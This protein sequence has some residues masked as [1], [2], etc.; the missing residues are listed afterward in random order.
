MEFC[1]SP[2]KT[3]VNR[4][5]VT[6]ICVTKGPP[7]CTL[8]RNLEQLESRRSFT[9]DQSHFCPL[10]LSEKVAGV[11]PPACPSE[12]YVVVAVTSIRFFNQIIALLQLLDYF[13]SSRQKRLTYSISMNCRVFPVCVPNRTHGFFHLLLI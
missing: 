6:G 12:Q 7:V 11:R 8:Y 10:K 1:V 3:R 4:I 13:E 9:R 5:R 2:Q